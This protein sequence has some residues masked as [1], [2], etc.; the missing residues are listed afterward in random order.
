MKNIL[1]LF[2]GAIL[3]SPALSAQITL[4]QSDYTSRITGTDSLKISASFSSFPSLAEIASGTWD[5][6][7]VTDSA[8]NFYAYRV[9]S[10]MYQFADSNIYNVLVFSYQGNLQS[11]ILSTGIMEYGVSIPYKGINLYAYGGG[12]WDSLII[13][14]QYMAYSS[15]HTK[16]SFPATFNT[17]WSSSYSADFHFHLTVGSFTLRDAPGFI[18]TYTNEKD[19]VTGWGTMRVKNRYGGPSAWFDVL[20]VQSVITTTDSFFLNGSPFSDS[21][22]LA[23]GITQGSVSNSYVQ[24]Y[25]R[26]GELTPFAQVNFSDGS[27]G[28]AVSAV[29][30]VSDLFNVGVPGLQQTSLNLFPNPVTSGNTITLTLPENS[31]NWSYNLTDITGKTV[32]KGPLT[33]SGTNAQIEIPLRAKP[34]N[35]LMKISDGNRQA[36]IKEIEITK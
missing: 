28:V 33:I 35:Y 16:I 10:A 3:L 9:P 34:G 32:A 13:D 14:S 8:P 22:L 30:Q 27:F 29:T 5:L 20:Q 21:L 24:N 2:A 12:R 23:L 19:S 26:T 36:F 6:S 1:L 31:G 7:T 4:T 11:S 15:P 18:R 17:S 25:Y